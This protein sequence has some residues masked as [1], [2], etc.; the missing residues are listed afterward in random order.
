M[1]GPGYTILAPKEEE[2]PPNTSKSLYH[3]ESKKSG[4]SFQLPTVSKDPHKEKEGKVW[5]THWNPHSEPGRL[6]TPHTEWPPTTL[7]I[8]ATNAG[9][10]RATRWESLSKLAVHVTHKSTWE[11]GRDSACLPPCSFFCILAFNTLTS[12]G[13]YTGFFPS[14]NNELQEHP[15]EFRVHTAPEGFPRTGPSQPAG[16]SQRLPLQEMYIIK[17]ECCSMNF[18]HTCPLGLFIRNNYLCLLSQAHIL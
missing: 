5:P 18:I 13:H 6:L 4:G 11:S 7:F 17:I 14:L 15:G 9:G 8:K 10:H 16:T 3:P 12:G 2:T 1:Q